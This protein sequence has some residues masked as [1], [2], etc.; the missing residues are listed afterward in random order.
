[1]TKAVAES[2]A[3]D[4]SEVESWSKMVRAVGLSK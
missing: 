1:M 2:N 4:T 3:Y